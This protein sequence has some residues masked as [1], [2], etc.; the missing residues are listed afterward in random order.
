MAVLDLQE[1]EQIEALK[2][3]WKFNRTQIIGGVLI[4]VVVLGGWRGWQYFQGKQA[5]EASVLYVEFSKQV[6]SNDLKRINDAAAA[7][8]DHHAAT[9]YATQA[10][11]LAAQSNEH[12]K[13]I[14]QA[15]VLL[16]W[17]ID[18]ASEMGLKE[19]A[20]LRLH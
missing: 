15:K 7:I 3:W 19:V 17:V 9:I 1:Q 10:A 8:M 4:A 20:R 18:H 14:T 5:G 6:G 16:Q 12:G 11:L 13:N 2:A